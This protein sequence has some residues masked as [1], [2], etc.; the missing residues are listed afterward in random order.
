[1]CFSVLVAVASYK[2]INV[3][4][5]FAFISARLAVLL[6]DPPTGGLATGAA[7]ASAF[8]EP[9]PA[10]GATVGLG[11]VGGGQASI[12]LRTTPC[13]MIRSAIYIQCA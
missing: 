2:Y 7:V 1:M 8:P 5:L 6:Y 3:Y 11:S 4:V 10:T 12:K 13:V 9:A